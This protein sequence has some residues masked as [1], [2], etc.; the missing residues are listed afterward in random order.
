[1]HKLRYLCRLSYGILKKNTNSSTYRFFSN[2]VFVI[3]IITLIISSN[4]YKHILYASECGHYSHPTQDSEGSNAAMTLFIHQSLACSC[5]TLTSEH[6][7]IT[8]SVIILFYN[9]VVN[10]S[11]HRNLNVTIFQIL[12]K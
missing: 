1:M 4:S 2:H 12:P 10:L 7:S 6:I 8:L 11:K 5:R 9:I 3:S